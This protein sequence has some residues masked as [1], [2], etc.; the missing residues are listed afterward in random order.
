MQTGDP[1]AIPEV[2]P[3]RRL[4]SLSCPG[5]GRGKREN[6]DEQPA[7]SSAPWCVLALSPHDVL[8]L[9]LLLT[10]GLEVGPLPLPH[11]F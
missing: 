3:P 8:S 4:P 11:E 10:A 7:V 5:K 9:H 6:Y 1:L 2:R